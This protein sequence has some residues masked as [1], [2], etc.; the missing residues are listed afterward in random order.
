[1]QFCEKVQRIWRSEFRQRHKSQT[2]KEPLKGS[3][4]VARY[5]MLATE[6]D[7]FR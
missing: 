2:D 6:K 4:H 1:M 5:V 3:V 7:P